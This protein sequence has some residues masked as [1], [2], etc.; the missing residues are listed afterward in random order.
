MPYTTC[1]QCHASFHIGLFYIEA[2]SCPRCGASFH[3]ARRNLRDQLRTAVFRHSV[4][5]DIVDWEA[6]T[7]SQYVDRQY[8]SERWRKLSR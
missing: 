4:C 3:P 6:I 2:E 8:V 7:G 1:P 5:E